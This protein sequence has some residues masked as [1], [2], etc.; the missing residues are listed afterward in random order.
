[1]SCAVI[2]NADDFGLNAAVNDAVSL[3]HRE[4]VLT[5]ASVLANGPA[6]A[7]ALAIARDLPAL[8]WAC[9]SR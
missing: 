5:S 1:M 6:V 9:I 2:V 4:G 7:D 3:A 8:G